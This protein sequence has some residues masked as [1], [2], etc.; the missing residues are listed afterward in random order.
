MLTSLRTI[1][2]TAARALGVERAAHAA[3]IEEV[4]PEVVGLEGAAH[5]RVLGVRGTVVLAEA[6]AGP[7]T[8]ELSAQRGRFM[9]EINRRLGG[10]VVTDIRFRQS[11]TP[12]V[13]SSRRGSG[14]SA[15]TALRTA[16]GERGGAE[17]TGE[18][19]L[20]AEEL[21]AVERAVEQIQDSEV[22]EA[23]RRAMISQMRW[24]KRRDAGAGGT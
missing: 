11:T 8:Q 19:P 17:P 7:W 4:W 24:R 5:S 1:L 3:L 12:V 15:G 9:A 21:A 13:P 16:P 10:A 6:E 23:A 20:S 18:P 22:R 2:R 14:R